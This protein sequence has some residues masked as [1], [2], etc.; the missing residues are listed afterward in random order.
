MEYPVQMSRA[1]FDF[2]RPSWRCGDNSR[3]RGA[4]RRRC[5]RRSR[6]DSQTYFSPFALWTACP[7]EQVNY[8]SSWKAAARPRSVGH[9]SAQRSIAAGKWRHDT[10]RRRL[11]RVFEYPSQRKRIAPPSKFPSKLPSVS[12]SCKICLFRGAACWSARL[13][14]SISAFLTKRDKRG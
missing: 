10:H 11:A 4:A 8:S 13:G 6:L 14:L 7:S 12:R 3:W 1:Q 5:P 9:R 2:S